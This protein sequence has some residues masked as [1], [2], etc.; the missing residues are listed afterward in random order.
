MQPRTAI[1][2]SSDSAVVSLQGLSRL[3]AAIKDDA[4]PATVAVSLSGHTATDRPLKGMSTVM[5]SS[6]ATKPNSLR[7]KS[8]LDIQSRTADQVPVSHPP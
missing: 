8:W 7:T 2:V 4:H 6:M 1:L 3:H 5:S